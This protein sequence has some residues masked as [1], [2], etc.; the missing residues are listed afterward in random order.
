MSWKSCSLQTL[1]P[2]YE[3]E[4]PINWENNFGKDAPLEVEIGFGQGEVLIKLA[5]EN[6][7]RNYVGIE[8]HWERIYK[9]LRTIRLVQEKKGDEVLQNVAILKID[10]WMA[11][12]R[13]FQQRSI[14]SMYCLFPC[15][16]PKKSHVKNR[17]F[18]PD[19]LRLL[20]SRLKDHGFIRFVTDHKNFHDW[21]LEQ[22]EGLGFKI[23]TKVIDPQFDTKFEK[24][25]REGGQEE[26]YEIRF[27]KQE[28][29]AIPVKEDVELK[30]YR[31]KN[32]DPDK[33]QFDKELNDV[34][35]V[36][37]GMLYDDKQRRAIIRLIVSEDHLVQ[38]FWVSITEKDGFWRVCKAEGQNILATPGISQ[39]ITAV[40]EAAQKTTESN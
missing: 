37:K 36:G 3:K 34:S 16:W 21:I 18:S 7:D 10:A 4:R 11:F 9:A 39:A 2:Y 35:I 23:S 33:F 15:P 32:F 17:L 1:V 31:L 40:Y 28:H 20:N 29:I 5:Q 6:P 30:S 8:L 19:F 38:H 14:D 27:E 12:E 25:W 13:L 24:K 26:F 22:S